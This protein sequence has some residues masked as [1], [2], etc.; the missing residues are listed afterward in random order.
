MNPGDTISLTYKLDQNID[1]LNGKDSLFISED[2]NGY[3]EAFQVEKTNFG[4]GAL[5]VKFTDSTNKTRVTP[6]LDY[7]T[8][9]KGR[10]ATY[11]IALRNIAIGTGVIVVCVAV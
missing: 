5:L 2:T 1:A 6:H 9:V 3:D 8:S 7:L 11:D 4:R 10:T